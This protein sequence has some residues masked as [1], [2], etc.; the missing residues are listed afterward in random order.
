MSFGNRRVAR[1]RG[2]RRL[3]HSVETVYALCIPIPISVPMKTHVIKRKFRAP[4]PRIRPFKLI[5][6]PPL[7][8]RHSLLCCVFHRSFLFVFD[9]TENRERE[10]KKTFQYVSRKLGSYTVMGLF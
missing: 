1:T 10:E 5:L 9:A 6:A 4:K 8:S 3:W 2:K 7:P